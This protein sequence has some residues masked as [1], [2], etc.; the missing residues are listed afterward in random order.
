MRQPPEK[1]TLMQHQ[2][3]NITVK[4]PAWKNLLSYLIRLVFSSLLIFLI[5]RTID[6]GK[7]IGI[8]SGINPLLFFFAYLTILL[9]AFPSAYAWKMLVEIQNFRV[10]YLRVVY[11]NLV[12]F[13]FNS[14]LPSGLGGD[15]WRGYTLARVSEKTGASVASVIMERFTAFASIV[16][17]GFVSFFLNMDT[18]RKA[19]ILTTV[20]VFFCLIILIFLTGIIL[21]PILLKKGNEKF[22]RYFPFIPD[23]DTGECLMK[24][25]DHPGR[26]LSALFMTSLSPLLECAGYILIIKSLELNVPY[27]PVFILVP[28]LRFINHIPVSL[29]SLGTQDLALLI[30]WQPLGL[31][32]PEAMSISILMHILRLLVGA[33]GGL[34]YIFFPYEKK[35]KEKEKE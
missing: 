18:F 32:A 33:T 2:A 22:H 31:S 12:G 24:Y 35:E 11:M 28:I 25:K 1:M 6:P 4:T 29:S 5:L 20:A 8:I 7:I 23:T 9:G 27:L 15:V 14:Y 13:F 34:L 26:V 16:L 10:P 17:L 19:G 3:N 30:F 21:I